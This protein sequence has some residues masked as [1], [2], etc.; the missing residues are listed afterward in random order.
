MS[1]ERSDKPLT[2]AL[3]FGLEIV[4]VAAVGD[5]EEEIGVLGLQKLRRRHC[6]TDA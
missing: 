2:Y 1:I 5:V 4:L 3:E 6:S